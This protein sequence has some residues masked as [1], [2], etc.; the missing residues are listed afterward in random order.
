M[1][2]ACGKEQFSWWPDPQ[3]IL[4]QLFACTVNVVHATKVTCGLWIN[5]TAHGMFGHQDGAGAPGFR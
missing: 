2:L 3:A 5:R 4:L 1:D